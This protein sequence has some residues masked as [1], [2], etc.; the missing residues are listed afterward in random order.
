MKTIKTLLMLGDSLVE[1]GDWQKLLP[2]IQVINRGIAGEH[3]EDLAARLTA[4][5]DTTPEPDHILIMAG[6]NNL[7]MGNRFFPAIFKSML[8]RLSLLCPDT[9]I[10]LNSIMPMSLP[11]F[12]LQTQEINKELEVVAG[13]SDCLFLNMTI[14]FTE[15]CLPITKPCF[16]T[17]GVHLS[18]LG[19]QVWA[20]EI[21]RHL[22]MCC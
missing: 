20:N 7:L 8:P 19:Y 9:D 6:T 16:L 5:L 14:P 11:G 13:Q 15:Q 1:W 22:T 3:V 4:E 21:R 10:T 12:S 17:D 18:T 2:D